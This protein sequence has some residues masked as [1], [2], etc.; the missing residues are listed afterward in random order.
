M[1]FEEKFPELENE[2]Y[3]ILET[4]TARQKG[5][6]I[7]LDYTEEVI[8]TSSIEKH[9]LS[10]QKVKEAIDKILP[11]L[12][13]TQSQQQGKFASIIREKLLKELGL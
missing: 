12:K 3:V 4:K 7:W 5:S 10:K 8:P 11:E 1:T 6:G 9:C 13:I 2:V